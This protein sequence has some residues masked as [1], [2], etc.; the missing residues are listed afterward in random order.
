MDSQQVNVALPELFLLPHVVLFK[1]E[2]LFRFGKK[3]SF[4][5]LSGFADLFLLVGTLLEL[6]CQCDYSPPQYSHSP[7]CQ[8][9]CVCSVSLFSVKTPSVSALM[10]TETGGK[11]RLDSAT[12]IRCTSVTFFFIVRF[13]N[14]SL[15]AAFLL[16]GVAGKLC[17]VKIL[18][19]L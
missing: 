18:Q 1:N 11:M 2:N 13:K 19:V 12:L 17:T 8:Q 14:R 5:I 15:Y 10:F 3:K 6:W 7:G 4:L 9:K 16:C